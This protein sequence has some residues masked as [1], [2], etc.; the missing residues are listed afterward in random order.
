[1]LETLKIDHTNFSVNCFMK[2]S[3]DFL[4]KLHNNKKKR[5][6]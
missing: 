2:I 5:L 3:Y 6:G 4:R 1:M